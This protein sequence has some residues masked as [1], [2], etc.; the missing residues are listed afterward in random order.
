M[1]FLL[2]RNLLLYVPSSYVFVNNILIVT[3]K[4]CLLTYIALKN[5]LLN[6]C[7]NAIFH[8]LLPLKLGCLSTLRVTVQGSLGQESCTNASY[9]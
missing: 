1:G 5:I 2:G 8:I 9:F 3:Q 7:I 4:T 6:D